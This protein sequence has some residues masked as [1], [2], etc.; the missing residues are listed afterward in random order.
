MRIDAA[1]I[2]SGDG[3]WTDRVYSF[4]FPR[5]GRRVMA[6]KGVAGARPSIQASKG[7][8]R[9]GRLWLVG[10]DTVKTTIFSRLAAR[11]ID[12]LFGELGAGLF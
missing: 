9:G 6:I 3:D 10:V 5:A 1:A 7:K 2:D 11:G 12:P 8:V 4:A